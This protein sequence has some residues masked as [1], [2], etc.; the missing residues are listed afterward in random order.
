MSLLYFLAILVSV[1]FIILLATDI[2]VSCTPTRNAIDTASNG[3][4][5]IKGDNSSK[6]AESTTSSTTLSSTKA[7][8]TTSTIKSVSEENNSEQNSGTIVN[9]PKKLR[10]DLSTG[11]LK[12]ETRVY[13]LYNLFNCFVWQTVLIL[14]SYFDIIFHPHQ[15]IA[16]LV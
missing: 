4:V 9:S 12:T 16:N 14:F 3:T 2:E 5:L 1:V 13:Y 7:T 6:S 15:S 10:E 8:A 11:T